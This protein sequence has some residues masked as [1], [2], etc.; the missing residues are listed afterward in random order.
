VTS[1]SEQS[2]ANRE[3]RTNLLVRWLRSELLVL[4]LVVV[5]FVAL[6]PFTPDLGTRENLGNVLA[7]LLPLFVLATGQTLVLIT[8]GIDLSACSIMALASVVGGMAMS[9]DGGWFAGSPL[10]APVGVGLMLAAGAAVGGTNGIAVTVLRMPPF[11]VTL[12]TMMF[13]SGLAIWLT[14]AETIGDLPPGFNAL[15][16]KTSLACA[17]TLIVGAATHLLLGHTVYGRWLYAIGQNSRMARISGV[18]VGGITAA[19]YVV[20]G[21][22]AGA[23]AILYTGQ[24]ETASPQLGQRMLLDVVAATVIG[25]TSLFGGR[26]KVLWTLAGVLFIK[27]LDNSLNL[28]NFSFFAIT[29]TKGGVVLA[30]ALLD[31]ARRRSLGTES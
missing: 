3:P 28:L 2:P 17:L 22:L 25:G 30:A 24:A 27:L 21:L 13:V 5:G 8:G 14:R 26:G 31:S 19:A 4:W 29:M 7:T 16:A 6:L 11:I 10:A 23:A 9:G 20:S 18:P 15:G 12:T 1:A